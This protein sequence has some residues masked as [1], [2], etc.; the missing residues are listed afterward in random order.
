[1]RMRTH[2]RTFMRI[3]SK[4]I[5]TTCAYMRSRASG[6]TLDGHLRDEI[7]M[8]AGERG[9]DLDGV[10]RGGR[11][12]F[13]HVCRQTIDLHPD[14]CARGGD[15]VVSRGETFPATHDGYEQRPP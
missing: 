1:M 9:A 4:G 3:R 5:A 13:A 15:G 2:E 6:S 11:V 14:P 8:R 7:P 12:Q 10:R